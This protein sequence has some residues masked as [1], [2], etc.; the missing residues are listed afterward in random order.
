MRKAILNQ[1]WHGVPA[2]TKLIIIGNYVNVQDSEI[3]IV[4]R[5]DG[6]LLP[7]PWDMHKTTDIAPEFLDIN[8]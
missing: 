4:E 8:S 5:E 3:L 6:E 2:G 7:T 1:D